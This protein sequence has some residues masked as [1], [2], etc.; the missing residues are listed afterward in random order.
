MGM[1]DYITVHQD[2]LDG[3][4]SVNNIALEKRDGYYSFQTK[5]LDNFLTEF[6]I[7][8]DESFVYKHQ[9]VE[10]V[11]PDVQ[12]DGWNFGYEKPVGDPVLISDNRSA[13]FTFHDLYHTD[14]HRIWCSF[15]AHV[16]NGKLVEP[17]KLH[18]LE[19]VDLAQEQVQSLKNKQLWDELNACWE[20]KLSCFV[21][22][23]QYK[24]KRLFRPLVRSIDDL[25]E[26][27][28]D[29]AKKRCNFDQI[30]RQCTSNDEQ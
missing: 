2:L 10:Y 27:L 16:A 18:K 19:K 7:E 20:W 1:F 9:E 26:R 14:T 17:I 11:K 3:L 28:R 8:S 13:Y 4:C 29:R 21:I 23:A 25:I 22:E 6:C 15:V 24:F 12:R 30:Q 5:D